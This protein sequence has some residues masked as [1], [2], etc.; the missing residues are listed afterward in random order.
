M[1]LVGGT[2]SLRLVFKISHS[3]FQETLSSQPEDTEA[4][5]LGTSPVWCLLTHCSVPS[6]DDLSGNFW[7]HWRHNWVT[8]LFESHTSFSGNCLMRGYFAE[9][10]HTVLFWKLTGKR[11]CDILLEW[12]LKRTCDVWREC[13]YNLTPDSGQMLLHWFALQLLLVFVDT[14]FTDNI[15]AMVCLAF[16]T[17]LHLSWLQGEKYIKE[18]LVSLETQAV[19][20]L[21]LAASSDSGGTP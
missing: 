16:F 3:P 7:F 17:H 8:Q 4:S 5:V 20:Q 9:K 10:R 15:L 13:K 6:H 12:K 18:L 19:F 2:V 1:C 21:L 14:V 11:V